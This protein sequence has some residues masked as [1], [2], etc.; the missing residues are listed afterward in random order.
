M[1][2][3]GWLVAAYALVIQIGSVHLGWHYAIDGYVGAALA[4]SIWLVAGA[5]LRRLGWPD[6]AGAGSSV[7]TTEVPNRVPAAARAGLAVP[8]G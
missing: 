1:S 4:L 8:E 3:A 6:A 2:V 5:L 7:R